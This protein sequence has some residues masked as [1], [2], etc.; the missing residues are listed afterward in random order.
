MIQNS[1]ARL[2]L[3]V[4]LLFPL[5]SLAPLAQAQQQEKKSEFGSS[6]RE[7]GGLLGTFYDLKQNQKRQPTNMTH[8][9][10]VQVLGEFFQKGLDESVLNR[11]FRATRSLYTTQLWIPVMKADAA[12]Q[13]FGVGAFVKP[14][15]WVAHYKGQV[16]PPSAGA[17]RFWGLGDDILCVAVNEKLVLM[18]NWAGMGLPNV[19]WKKPDVPAQ[20]FA[21]SSK[22]IPG[23]WIEVKDH[24]TLDLD[25]LIG[26]LP[27]SLFCTFLL[28]EKRGETYEMIN[29]VPRL[30]I[31]QLAPYETP[32]PG[33]GQKAPFY[34]PKGPVW[35]GVE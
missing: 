35:K 28:V 17:Y 6:E 4:L 12:P 30:P 2:S 10:Y 5:F 27:G 3:I 14:R 26:E 24:E 16:I 1:T 18:S 11:Y 21:G 32:Q 33:P 22:I 23:D 8:G 34:A 7:Q 29:G 19:P 31:F 13:A 9:T 20:P 15:M 25:V